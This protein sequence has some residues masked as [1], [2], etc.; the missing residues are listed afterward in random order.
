MTA[1]V[2]DDQNAMPPAAIG[3]E[4]SA[5]GKGL[6][7]HSDRGV[8]SRNPVSGSL[9]CSTSP[10]RFTLIPRVL[11]RDEQSIRA[12]RR[13]AGPGRT[14]GGVGVDS[15]GALGSGLPRLRAP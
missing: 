4:S 13:G 10:A 2:V 15:A 3:L 8:L 6:L 1:G 9:T 14:G 5:A 12:R 11:H 7:H